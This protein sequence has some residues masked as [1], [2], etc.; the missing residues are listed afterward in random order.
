MLGYSD[1]KKEGLYEL[2][3]VPEE[4]GPVERLVDDYKIKAF[5]FSQDDY[6]EWYFTDNTPF[7]RRI[8]PAGVL[9]NDLMAIFLTKYHSVV[10]LHTEEELRFHTPV[11]AG[12]R[13]TLTGRY[14][15]KYIK[16][17]MGH[18]VLDTMAHGEDGRLVMQHHGTEVMRVAA[19]AV[20]GRQSAEAVPKRV[21]G[22]FDKDREP[23]TAARLDL[24]PG[25]PTETLT[26]VTHQDQMSVFSLAGQ[27][28]RNVHNDLDI[29]R[30]AGLEKTLMQGQQQVCYAI[31]LMTRFF[32]AAWFTSGRLRVKFIAPVYVD[33]IIEVQGVV[34]GASSDDE[35]ERL[36]LEVWIRNGAG[37]LS[38][39]GWASA[40]PGG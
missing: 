37:A 11:F 34:T 36:D 38:T 17:G 23:A 14:V 33:E 13:V 4:F 28:V 26:K 7:Q 35:G 32:G 21:T 1:E 6:N 30:R 31:E 25:T 9:A 5:A 39:V 19:G 16:R 10:G 40:R 27:Y 3:E 2:V 22:E 20:V 8:A 18:V 29:A 15:D 24:H 12:E